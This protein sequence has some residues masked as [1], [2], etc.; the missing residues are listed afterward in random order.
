METTVQSSHAH[1]DLSLA[2]ELA[3][4]TSIEMVLASSVRTLRPNDADPQN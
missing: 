3:L 2:L 1:F 4:G